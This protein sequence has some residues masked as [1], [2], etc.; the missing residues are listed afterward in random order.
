MGSCEG[1]GL[2]GVWVV[3]WAVCP[4]ARKGASPVMVR[5][6]G[7]GRAPSPIPRVP[8]ATP[9]ACSR[10]PPF[11][12]PPR[13]S[14]PPRHQPVPPPADPRHHRPPFF[15]PP[16]RNFLAT[17]NPFIS[18]ACRTFAL[19]GDAKASANDVRSHLLRPWE[20]VV[21]VFNDADTA[22]LWATAMSAGLPLHP[23]PSPHTPPSPRRPLP[24]PSS[25]RPSPP[26]M[27]RFSL[28]TPLAKSQSLTWLTPRALPPFYVTRRAGMRQGGDRAGPVATATPCHSRPRRQSPPHVQAAAADTLGGRTLPTRRHRPPRPSSAGT[29]PCAVARRTRP[30]TGSRPPR[31]PWWWPRRA[32]QARGLGVRRRQRR[33]LWRL[34]QDRPRCAP[35]CCRRAASGTATFPSERRSP[36]SLSDA[37]ASPRR[38][39]DGAAGLWEDPPDKPGGGGTSGCKRR[40]HRLWELGR[41]HGARWWHDG[42]QMGGLLQRRR[43][44]VVPTRHGRQR[45]HPVRG[46]GADVLRH[47]AYRGRG[48]HLVGGVHDAAGPGTARRPPA[49]GFLWRPYPPRCG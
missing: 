6:G 26:L 25:S 47:G 31:C 43:R 24:H 36:A 13:P 28:S 33:S 42:A 16:P 29:V 2:G 34:R 27:G 38:L 21:R 45:R 46:H 48:G 35:T 30:S 9:D 17:R 39:F 7:G 5:G 23:P 14:E 11:F 44:R 40:R 37:A 32:P 15:V 49:V 3:A 1:G 19:T 12:L 4:S 10:C 20:L 22:E 18:A 41:C 8:E